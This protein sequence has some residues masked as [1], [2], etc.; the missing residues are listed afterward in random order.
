[1]NDFVLRISIFIAVLCVM[2]MLE[3]L[4]PRRPIA[5][6]RAR[7]W[8]TNLAIAGLDSL[9]LRLLAQLSVPVAAVAAAVAAERNG[10]GLFHALDWPWP[11]EMALGVALLDAAIYLQ[12]V[13]SH[14]VP[15]LWR[16][17][18]V[19]HADPAIDVT[20]GIRFHPIEIGLSMLYKIVLVML[21]GPSPETVVA[22]E[23]VLNATALFN[24]ANVA[25]PAPLDRVLRLVLVTPDM[26]RIHHSVHRYEH[27]S[28]YGFAL[29]VWDRLLGTY[30]HE[31]VDGHLAMTIGLSDHQS[32]EPTRLGWSLGLPFAR[33]R[34][35]PRTK[36]SDRPPSQNTL[37]G[38]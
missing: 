22:F 8:W 31:P 28:N 12:H 9:M 7:R 6:P 14:R 25:L 26:H 36:T 17:H 35:D 24:H 15:L 13:A 16:V 18:R 30:R 5:H 23:I 11:I 3:L 33:P 21:L 1:M 27:D 4:A 10:W 37:S 20:T 2:A 32:D 29:S 38:K 34:P 19:H